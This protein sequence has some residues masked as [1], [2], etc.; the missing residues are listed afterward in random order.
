MRKVDQFSLGRLTAQIFACFIA[1]AS[2]CGAQER[3]PSGK[4]NTDFSR[5]YIFVDKSGVVGHQHAVEGKLASGELFQ[6][7]GREGKLTFDMQSF[8]ADTPQAKKYLALENAVDEATRKKVN[9]NMLGAE[10]LNVKKYTTAKFE[11]VTIRPKNTTSKRQLP[12]YLL[13]GDFTLHE[14][15][16]RIEIPCD[17]EVKD[18]WHHYRGSFKI[19][20]SNYGIKPYSKMLGAVGVADEL[21]IYGDIWVVPE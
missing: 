20:Q 6:K 10:I 17:L 12:E 4:V 7:E 8:N 5:V 19:L 11:H 21:V 14:K 13:V 2:V 9:E 16:R 3:P 18:G 1:I 15:T